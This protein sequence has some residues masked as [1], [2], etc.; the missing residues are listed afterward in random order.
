MH[1]QRKLHA[2]KIEKILSL[3]LGLILRTKTIHIHAHTTKLKTKTK[4][5]AVN[6]GEGAG[7]HFKS[8][9]IIIFKCSLVNKI[10]SQG[11]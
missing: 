6:P 10:K 2:P 9:H 8:Y 11:I 1:A 5:K 7:S 4:T 3:Y